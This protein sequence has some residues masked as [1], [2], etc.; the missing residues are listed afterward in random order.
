VPATGEEEQDR[1]TDC[2]GPRL[3]IAETALTMRYGAVIRTN[4]IRGVVTAGIPALTE[5][6]SAEVLRRTGT[7]S[8]WEALAHIRGSS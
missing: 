6:Y 8:L 5:K 1:K 4:T 3:V 7:E 2:R